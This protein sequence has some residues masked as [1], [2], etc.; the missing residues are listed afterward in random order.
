MKSASHWCLLRH[1]CALA[2]IT[3]CS[4][5]HK[6]ALVVQHN[7]AGYMVFAATTCKYVF[8]HEAQRRL[9]VH[10]GLRL[11]HRPHVPHVRAAA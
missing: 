7:T 9:L 1:R 10:R 5:S 8:N 11:D 3:A 6:R 2:R 4:Y